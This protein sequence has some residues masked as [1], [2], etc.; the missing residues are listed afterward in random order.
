MTWPGKTIIQQNFYPS[1][2]KGEGK[3][4]FKKTD[5]MTAAQK[6]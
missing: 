2:L 4:R 6:H 3:S 5:E 1:H